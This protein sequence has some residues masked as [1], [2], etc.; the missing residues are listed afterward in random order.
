MVPSEFKID[1]FGKC[2]IESYINNLP[3]TETVLYE[4][5][6]SYSNTFEFYR[7]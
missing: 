7:D 4:N 5:I 6:W 2:K 3:I 1:K